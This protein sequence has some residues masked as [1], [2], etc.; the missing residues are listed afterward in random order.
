MKR[1]L[2]LLLLLAGLA[3]ETRAATLTWIGGVSSCWNTQDANWLDEGGNAVAYQDGDAVVFNGAAAGVITLEGTL[4]PGSV[5]V[6]SANDLTFTG[7]GW[8]TG[9]MALAK[10]GSG[11]LT[12]ATANDYTGGNTVTQSTLRI[13]EN[14]QLGQWET[15]LTD[16]TVVLGDGVELRFAN[17]KQEDF[18]VVFRLVGDCSVQ[19]EGKV[20]MVADGHRLNH[21]WDTKR[22][23]VL[24]DAA[25]LNWENLAKKS[26]FLMT[27]GTFCYVDVF[28]VQQGEKYTLNVVGADDITLTHRNA[29]ID[30]VFKF[31]PGWDYF[32][33]ERYD[34]WAWDVYYIRN[35]HMGWNEAGTLRYTYED[36]WNVSKNGGERAMLREVRFEELEGSYETHLL[37]NMD[38]VDTVKFIVRDGMTAHLHQESGTR[39]SL[40]SF[41]DMGQGECVIHCDGGGEFVIDGVAGIPE[42]L[43]FNNWDGT[44][45]RTGGASDTPIQINQLIPEGCDYS[46][47]RFQG[48]AVR[49]GTEGSPGG[50]TVCN[51]QVE[52]VEGENGVAAFT[53]A[54]MDPAYSFTWA[55][56]LSGNGDIALTANAETPLFMTFDCDISDWTGTFVQ[57]GAQGAMLYVNTDAVN[58][59]LE[60]R[61]GMLMLDLNDNTQLHSE[62][63]VAASGATITI[64]GG[65]NHKV[66]SLTLGDG[67]QVD[68]Y[69]SNYVNPNLLSVTGSLTA[70]DG[71]VL[72]ASLDLAEGAVLDLTAWSGLSMEGS[73]H[74]YGDL[75][76]HGGLVLGENALQYIASLDKGDTFCLFTGVGEL[77]FPDTEEATCYPQAVDASEVFNNIAPG[78]Y[79]LVYTGSPDVVNDIS[80]QAGAVFL[81]KLV[82]IPEPTTGALSLLGFGLL[83]GRRRK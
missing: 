51:N 2:A 14:G 45:I 78:R 26:G 80:G 43:S 65:C 27:P 12:I 21:F 23:Q 25:G 24:R 82:P 40:A 3:V 66:K 8:L 69:A 63:V 75:L 1:T 74:N 64:N 49:L 7:D 47:L 46:T 50:S 59:S 56:G 29:P 81:Q 4:A 17:P 70:G 83:A 34:S 48:C 68:A 44:I 32:S 28:E 72:Y 20:H 38:V 22:P 13:V 77:L 41:L 62:S 52:L 5:T 67:A 37:I 57:D 35:E 42:N 58:A 11:V 54:E 30:A 71:S 16:S 73:E 79:N 55:G 36:I 39:L 9:G 31:K 61:R 60:G 76:L 53:I 18:P 33:T 6:N 19:C 10:T 15:K